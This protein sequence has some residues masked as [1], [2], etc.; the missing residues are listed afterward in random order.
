MELAV[1]TLEI[2]DDCPTPQWAER[3][4]PVVHPHQAPATSNRGNAPLAAAGG[5][6]NHLDR[7]LAIS[8]RAASRAFSPGANDAGK[9]SWAL[10]GVCLVPAIEAE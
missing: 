3:I 1:M 2:S 6:V 10:G 9:R 8:G 5:V 4:I 7:V